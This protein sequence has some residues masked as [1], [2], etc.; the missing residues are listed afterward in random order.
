[1]TSPLSGVPAGERLLTVPDVADLLGVIVTRVMDELNRHRLIAVD[2]D[3]VRHIPARFF[4]D[5]A[6]INKFVPGVIALLADGAWEDA[7]ILDF[8]FSDD[9]SLPGRPVDA[10]HGHLAREV[11]RRAQAMAIS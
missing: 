3:G 5:S 10:L 2:V 11:M 7:E 8:L 6:E 9:E 1:M 4:T